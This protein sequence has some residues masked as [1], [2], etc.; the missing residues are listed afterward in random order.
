MSEN[1]QQ[2]L[3]YTRD[4]EAKFR[5]AARLTWP[6]LQEIAAS[7]GK[8][9]EVLGARRLSVLT[10]RLKDAP[11][12]LGS[13]ALILAIEGYAAPSATGAAGR[14]RRP[15]VRSARLGPWRQG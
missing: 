5:H 12:H 2:S 4:V 3:A 6:K 11:K 7:Y 1:G 13:D 14:S 15:R 8:R 10:A 9:W